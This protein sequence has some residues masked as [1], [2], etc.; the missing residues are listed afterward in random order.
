MLA[1]SPSNVNAL[2]TTDQSLEHAHVREPDVDVV[3]E[4]VLQDLEQLVH[5]AGD[6]V[7]DGALL[8]VIAYFL[9]NRSA[10]D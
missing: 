5:P 10:R 4:A 1:R 8:A 6:G 2:S 3:V 9:G 7:V